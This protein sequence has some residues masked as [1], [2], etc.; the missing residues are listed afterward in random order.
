VWEHG[1]GQAGQG[2]NDIGAKGIQLKDI[3]SMERLGVVEVNLAHVVRHDG[4]PVVKVT[5]IV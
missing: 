1:I 2:H 4:D 3:E 5:P